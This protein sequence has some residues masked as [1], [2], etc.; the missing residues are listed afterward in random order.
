MDFLRPWNIDFHLTRDIDCF[1]SKYIPFTDVK[2]ISFSE[3][4]TKKIINSLIF[5]KITGIRPKLA[6]WSPEDCS[7]FQELAAGR[8]FMAEIKNIQDITSSYVTEL[9][10]ISSNNVNVS[11]KL[12][13]ENRAAYI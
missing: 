7:H 12:V 6:K 4:F 10:L 11:E 9:M 8:T 3:N 1:I 13:R 5:D 2:I